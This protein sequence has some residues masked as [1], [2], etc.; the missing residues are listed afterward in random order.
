MQATLPL[1]DNN[2]QLRAGNGRHWQLQLEYT[3]KEYSIETYFFQDVI[4][5]DLADIG[6]HPEK[7]KKQTVNK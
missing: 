1:L 5:D 4:Q 7:E 6:E 2:W 3:E